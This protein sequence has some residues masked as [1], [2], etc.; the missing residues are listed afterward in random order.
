MSRRVLFQQTA[1]LRLQTRAFNKRVYFLHNLPKQS[2]TFASVSTSPT[3]HRRE[4]NANHDVLI[5]GSGAAGLAAALRAKAHGLSPLLVEK[6]PQV[7][8]TS[9]YSGGGVWI[10][11]S[12]LHGPE[13]NDSREE[14][15][16]YME[17]LIGDAG[18]ASSLERKL[19]FLDNGPEMVKWLEDE[20]F[21]WIPSTGYP[22]YYPN[23]PG[24]KKNGRSIEGGMFDAKKLGTWR[25]KLVRSPHIPP[26]PMHTFEGT[27][28]IRAGSSLDG[29]ATFMN[30]IFGRLLPQRLLGRDPAVMGRTLTGQLLHLNLKKGNPIWLKSQMKNL[31]LDNG[32]VTGAVIERDGKPFD[33][34]APRG[35]LLAAGGFAHNAK[36][37]ESHQPAPSSTE[38][39]AAQPGD[40]GDAISAALEL[41]AATA[42]MDD[43][44]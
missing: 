37:R 25:E 39:T 30:V 10:P 23:L 12:H 16:K 42:L 13:V 43:A 1:F 6:N 34:E 2:R 33:V 3:S 38:W 21:K 36:M 18:P 40:T 20:G 9:A 8:G 31:I 44:W 32:R 11:N 29:F 19:A 17:A 26:L 27:R 41:G 35:V 14:A 5:I 22:D 4:Q 24:G 28:L 15:L 7:G